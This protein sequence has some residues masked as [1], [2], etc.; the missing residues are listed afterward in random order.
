MRQVEGAR[1]FGIQGFKLPSRMASSS[2]I[3][4]VQPRLTP[5][6]EP[7]PL[8]PKV[9]SVPARLNLSPST[10]PIPLRPAGSYRG[11]ERRP[12]IVVRINPN[13]IGFR[14]RL[15]PQ[16]EQIRSPKLA[17]VPSPERGKILKF[18]APESAEQL[19]HSPFRSREHL[20]RVINDAEN[21]IPTEKR[22][23]LE[24]M[25]WDT[26]LP[27]A[28]L[29]RFAYRK[30]QPH[31]RGVLASAHVAGARKG[32]LTIYKDLEVL[33]G[34]HLAKDRLGREH[35]GTVVHEMM[36]LL[37]PLDKSHAKLY[38]SEMKRMQAEKFAEDFATQ[39]ARS[40]VFLN[41]YHHLL[42][43][44]L[45]NR[46]IRWKTWVE[47]SNAILH[48][49]SVINPNKV[50]QVEASQHNV[51]DTINRRYHSKIGKVQLTSTQKADG[52]WNTSIVDQSLMALT[53]IQTVDALQNHWRELR[54]N[55]PPA[56]QAR[57]YQ[58]ERRAQRI[59]L[60]IPVHESHRRKRPIA[61]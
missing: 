57:I 54:N 8:R 53:G 12:R 7:T 47:E 23:A 31:E 38:G 33:S 50:K 35:I 60:L 19:R 5:Y 1:Q 44:Q 52:S 59:V 21:P 40:Q 56:T 61:A 4:T 29:T 45:V 2:R 18:R 6:A 49:T 41:G 20:A 11:N 30:N 22:K 37:S 13:A 42:Y 3:N 16:P 36:H 48:E 34:R 28:T 15:S 51:I 9:P 46:E 32:M 39:S 10:D 58:P 27:T 26:K 25:I 14:P 55:Y 43:T 17:S 24:T